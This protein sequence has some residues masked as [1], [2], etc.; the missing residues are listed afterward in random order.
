MQK[1]GGFLNLKSKKTIIST[2]A[3]PLTVIRQSE[4]LPLNFIIFHFVY[5]IYGLTSNYK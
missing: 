3:K 5:C 2:I 4:V 1:R